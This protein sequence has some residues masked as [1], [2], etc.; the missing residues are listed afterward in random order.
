MIVQSLGWLA[1]VPLMTGPL[2]SEERV[3]TAGT[4]NGETITIPIG[5]GEPEQAPCDIKGC[6]AAN[7]RK[8]FDLKQTPPRK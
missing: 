4:C 1:L 5:D 7:C 2:P 6:H 3:L 8:Q